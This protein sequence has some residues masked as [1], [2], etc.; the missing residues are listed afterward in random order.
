MGIRRRNHRPAARPLD[1][2]W[3][4]SD[5]AGLLQSSSVS[6]RDGT[7]TLSR[8]DTNA[9]KDSPEAQQL[10]VPDTSKNH[11]AHSRSPAP[12]QSSGAFKPSTS[13]SADDASFTSQ[14]GPETTKSHPQRPARKRRYANK[15]HSHWLE[16][17]DQATD[18]NTTHQ[19]QAESSRSQPQADSSQPDGVATQQQQ[20]QHQHWGAAAGEVEVPSAP[21]TKSP[22][23]FRP[24]QY[25]TDQGC[26][27]PPVTPT[28]HPDYSPFVD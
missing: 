1:A 10:D 20:G 26:D 7:S 21:S 15:H 18:N 11:S 8:K 24:G 9:K 12:S 13:V 14:Q 6:T 17:G 3:I 23:I 16:E 22:S 25:F 5:D 4:E 2:S 19:P 27:A 28:V